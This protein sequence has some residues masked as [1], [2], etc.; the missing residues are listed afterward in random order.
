[1]AKVL[2]EGGQ[3]ETKSN[4]MTKEKFLTQWEGYIKEI[5]R[6]KWN[7]HKSK[8]GNLDKTL[9]QLMD[10]VHQASEDNGRTI[11]EAK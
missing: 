10:L 11:M 2:M 3:M 4:Q 9:L 1:M 5:T 6:L 8:H 7:L